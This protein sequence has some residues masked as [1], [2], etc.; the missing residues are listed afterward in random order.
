MTAKKINFQI[1]GIEISDVRLSHPEND[2]PQAT[3]YNFE[4]N[5]KHKIVGE[6]NLI[7]VAPTITI[8]YDTDQEI[9]GSITVNYF[10]QVE[11]LGHFKKP[12][13]DKYDL[14]DDF[15]AT[16]N[17]ISISTTRGIMFSQF[18]GT[19]L[20]N[21]VLPVVNPGDFKNESD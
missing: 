4:I 1:R 2:L 6:D 14:P 8:I 18:K 13:S 12:E 17:S 7:I 9:H 19:F 21:T 16:L 3:R 15:I 11:N 10:F 20:H 5:L